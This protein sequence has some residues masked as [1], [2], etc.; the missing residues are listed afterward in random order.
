M[1]IE[2]DNG[3]TITVTESPR[4]YEPTPLEREARLNTMFGFFWLFVLILLAFL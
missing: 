1:A 3:I 4:K 2:I